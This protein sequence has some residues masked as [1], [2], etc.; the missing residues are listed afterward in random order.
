[1]YHGDPAHTG[2]VTG[3]R[4]TAKNVSSLKLHHRLQLKGPIMS[5]PAIVDGILYVG[6]ANS[7]EPV[8][9]DGKPVTGNGGALYRIDL[10]KGIILEKFVWPIDPNERDSHGFTGMGC[11]PAVIDGRV[12]FSAFNGCVYAL[13]QTTLKLIWCTNLRHADLPH[14]QPAENTQGLS[15]DNHAPPVAGWASPVVAH[16]NVYVGVGEGENPQAFSFVYCLD[17]A[18]GNVKWLFCTNKFSLITDNEPNVLPAQ[19]VAMPL[20]QGFKVCSDG[21]ITRGSSVWAG[22]AYD[23]GLDRLYCSTGNPNPDGTLPTIGYTNGILALDATTG[24]FKGFTQ[25]PPESCYR[26]S[27]ADVDIGGSVTVFIVN[28]R[29]VVGVGG[30]NG[31]Y[32]VLDAETL[33]MVVWR[34]M[35]PLLNKGNQQTQRRG[36]VPKGGQPEMGGQIETVD[37]HG[38]DDPTN[39]NPRLTNEQSNSTQQE[40]FFGT[41]STASVHP[42]LGRLFIGIGGNNYH[43]VAPGI[44]SATTPFLRAMDWA[45]L[46]DAW[47]LDDHDPPRYRLA[48]PPMY[49]T[50]AESGLSAPAVV[51]D[52][53]FTGT[54]GVKLYAF[55]AADGT[56]LWSDTLG[57]ETESAHG[58]YGYCMGPAIW[59]DYVVAG[60][61][62]VGR[63]G[64]I[65][66]I[67]KLTD[68]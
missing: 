31:S 13:D 28:G 16:G 23:E 43:S 54:T 19:I 3:S 39:P 27:D 29:K 59:G 15:D 25:F 17:G 61:L 9:S 45:T 8:G 44:D 2:C 7:H 1:M 20:P 34:Q 40:N 52:V 32:M 51:N 57:M 33:E 22:I 64:G 12:Y 36:P 38:P 26:P 56:P 30:K 4:I 37:P 48:L 53:V 66:R 42:G 21:P 5:V 67:Y 47:P 46:E 63:D 58:G 41:Y 49:T 35:L 18:T 11:T 65:L 50:P 14:N 6:T 10:A 60:A 55:S 62:I 68:A 24:A